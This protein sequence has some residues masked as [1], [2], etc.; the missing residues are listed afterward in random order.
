MVR[1]FFLCLHSQFMSSPSR[2][3]FP[4]CSRGI[5]QCSHRNL[6]L[7]LHRY[8]H[9]LLHCNPSHIYFHRYSIESLKHSSR[10]QLLDLQ[11]LLCPHSLFVYS[12]FHIDFRHC[13]R[14]ILQHNC[15][16]RL[17]AHYLPQHS[18]LPGSLFCS[19]CCLIPKLGQQCN[20]MSW[21]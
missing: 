10:S 16:N 3:D 20:H 7:V 13:S 19:C 11:F 5:L 14:E 4:R 12:S 17:L 9:F 2:I 18:P 8:R 15:M 6:L 21:L 1:L